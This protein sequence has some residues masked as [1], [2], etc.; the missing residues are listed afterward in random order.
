[1]VADMSEHIVI[2]D[3][4]A[5]VCQSL[6]ESLRDAG[7]RTSTC[8]TGDDL[9]VLLAAESVDLVVVDLI[10][11]GEDGLDIVRR[12]AQLEV[13]PV[14]IITGER[15]EDADKAI[16]LE[17][18]ADDYIEK[19]FGIREFIAR[20]AVCLR[21]PR[22][23]A[24]HEA[25]RVL[26]FGGWTLNL[27]LRS[28]HDSQGV[29]MQLTANEFRVLT[30]FVQSPYTILSRE[31]LKAHGID[32]RSVDIVVNRLRRK[33]DRDG[34]LRSLIETERGLGYR[35]VAP[36]QHLGRPTEGAMSVPD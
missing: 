13:I 33:L 9:S 21:K 7:F 27:R 17:F 20:I 28:L 10:L 29:R 3:D 8:A 5:A 11:D 31:R 25:E 22:I 16:G 23:A 24:A 4:D 36:V 30:A 14:V 12:V 2:V 34:R 1:M 18:G 6:S 19:P 32:E 35:F 26:R 15:I